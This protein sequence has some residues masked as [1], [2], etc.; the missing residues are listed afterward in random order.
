MKSRDRDVNIAPSVGESTILTSGKHIP[1]EERML[2]LSTNADSQ[3]SSD[4]EVPSTPEAELPKREHLQYLYKKLA[5]GEGIT[6]EKRKNSL[7]DT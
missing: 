1:Q 7:L 4:F 5:T 3:S 2:N 6:V